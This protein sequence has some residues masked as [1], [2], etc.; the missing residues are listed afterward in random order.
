[1][2]PLLSQALTELV[3]AVAKE[4]VTN[5]FKDSKVPADI[6]AKFASNDPQFGVDADAATTKSQVKGQSETVKKAEEQTATNDDGQTDDRSAEELRAECLSLINK[7]APT[8]GP[9]IRKALA[10][11]K[12]KRLSEVKDEDLSS[13]FNAL[14]GLENA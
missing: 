8:Q 5:I 14:R 4:V 10:A 11:V 1:M 6:A 7:F 13:I 3:R 2:N 12:A 9:A